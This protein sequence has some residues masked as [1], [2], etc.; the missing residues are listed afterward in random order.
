MFEILRTPQFDGW[1][2]SLA[3]DRAHTK[4]LSRISNMALGNFGPCRPV[5]EGLSESKIDHGPG[6]RIYFVC[7]G[8]RVIVLLAGGDKSTQTRDIR[9]AKALAKGLG[10]A[11]GAT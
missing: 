10:P 3:G 8:T 4:V 7:R 6:Y 1:L 9:R 5:G 2:A 11:L